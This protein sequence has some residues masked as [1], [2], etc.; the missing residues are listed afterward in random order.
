MIPV[1]LTVSV[2]FKQNNTTFKTNEESS[3]FISHRDIVIQ[4]TNS[5]DPNVMKVVLENAKVCATANA[6]A[7]NKA[8]T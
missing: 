5:N 2:T 8:V 3:D 1:G 4:V 6:K 7:K